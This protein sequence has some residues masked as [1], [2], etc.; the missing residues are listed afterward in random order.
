MAGIV[1][2]ARSH[3]A[4]WLFRRSQLGLVLRQHVNGYFRVLKWVDEPTKVNVTRE[5]YDKVFE[6]RRAPDPR[7][8]L[9]EAMC[10]VAISTAELQTLCMTEEEK[11]GQQFAANPYISG[12]LHRHIERAAPL[13]DEFAEALAQTPSLTA[14]ELM[15]FA[16]RRSALM[17]FCLNGLQ[18]VRLETNDHI[19]E[20]D[21]LRPLVEAQMAWQED[22]WREKLGLP[23]LVPPPYY[24]ALRYSGFLTMVLNGERNPLAAWRAAAPN[25]YLAGYGTLPGDG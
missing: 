23:R 21:W 14:E 9:R 19:A 7:M 1:D 15:G 4:G 25:L 20:G 11:A 24:D 22:L 12:E 10:A 17:L 3:V 16:N 6:V 13:S 18:L 8:A 2:T 5:L